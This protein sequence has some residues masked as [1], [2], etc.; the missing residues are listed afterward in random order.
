[1]GIEEQRRIVAA[2]F[3]DALQFTSHQDYARKV[4]RLLYMREFIT[5]FPKSAP[6]AWKALLGLRAT[7]DLIVTSLLDGDAPLDMTE[8]V[9]IIHPYA[10]DWCREHHISTPAGWMELLA[11]DALA[12]MP[13]WERLGVPI[14]GFRFFDEVFVDIQD[15]QAR[16]SVENIDLHP[17]ADA[18]IYACPGFQVWDMLSESRAQ[19]RKRAIEEYT[20]RLDQQIARAESE[21]VT[22]AL[23]TVNHEWVRWTLLRRAEGKSER[24]VARLCG[25]TRPAVNNG[26]RRVSDILSFLD[27]AT[28]TSTS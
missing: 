19:F 22:P 24:A 27:P 26:V 3:S 9:R 13:L 23:A 28:G 2:E 7:T 16:I 4:E 20:Q 6:T 8:A 25:V 12:Q 1:M 17:E 15:D 14:T 10:K 5:T 11:A 18:L 21:S